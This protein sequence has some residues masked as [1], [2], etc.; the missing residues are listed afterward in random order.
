MRM[1]QQRSAQGPNSDATGRSDPPRRVEC[2]C[3]EPGSL[4]R[5]RTTIPSRLTARTETIRIELGSGLMPGYSELV[6][7]RELSRALGCRGIDVIIECNDKGAQRMLELAG[8]V[9]DHAAR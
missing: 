3:T 4:A 7:L 9:P 6:Q 1:I 2:R 8:L 5:L